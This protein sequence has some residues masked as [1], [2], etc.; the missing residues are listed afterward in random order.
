MESLVKRDLSRLE[1]T[2]TGLR[3]KPGFNI[4]DITQQMA[5]RCTELSFKSLGLK[6]FDQMILAAVLVRS[7]ELYRSGKT[8]LAFCSLEADL[9]PW[10]QSRNPKMPIKSL[11][12][13]ARVWVHGDFLFQTPAKPENWSG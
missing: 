4:F 8:D 13:N 5:E 9:Q 2:L 10:D 6:P 1:E 3:K 11:Y 12:D 7:E